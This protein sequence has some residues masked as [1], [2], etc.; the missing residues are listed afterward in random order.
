[1]TFIEASGFQNSSA[2]RRQA[3]GQPAPFGEVVV[4]PTRAMNLLERALAEDG[5]DCIVLG[6]AGM[7]DLVRWFERKGL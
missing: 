4:V 3:V 1:M 6:C 7:A 2:I 5:S